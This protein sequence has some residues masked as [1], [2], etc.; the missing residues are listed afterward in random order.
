MFSILLTRRVSALL[1]SVDEASFRTRL[2]AFLVK[3]TTHNLARS[4]QL[5]ALRCAPIC[6]Q[7]S[8]N[9]LLMKSQCFA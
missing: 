2:R 6:F 7:I 5:E 1:T 9:N 3:M 8:H 4:R